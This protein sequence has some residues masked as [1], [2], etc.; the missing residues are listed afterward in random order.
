MLI[1]NDSANK[2][3]IDAIKKQRDVD[4]SNVTVIHNSKSW[5][6]GVVDMSRFESKISRNRNFVWKADD[7][8]HVNLTPT[9]AENIAKKAD[10]ALTQIFFDAEVAIANL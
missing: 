8:E 4:M 2:S 6:F 5:S 10:D 7:G 9:V 1:D 3:A